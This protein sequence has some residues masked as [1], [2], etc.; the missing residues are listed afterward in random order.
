[1]PFRSRRS[2][3][4]AATASLLFA[5]LDARAASDFLLKIDGIEGESMMRG[6]EK[7]IEIASFS[8][9]VSQAAAGASSRAG[10]ACPSDLALSKVVDKATPPLISN[11]VGGSVS[12]AA[13]LIGLRGTGDSLPEPYIRIEMKN[14]LVSS[15][16]TSGSSGGGLAFDAFSLRF[17]SAKITYYARDEKGAGAAVTSSVPGSCS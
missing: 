4:A 5:T 9:G 13:V 6:F 2:F 11:A 15:Y 12:P 7:Q 1:M 14:V 17:E 8:W 10:K 3:L 16:S